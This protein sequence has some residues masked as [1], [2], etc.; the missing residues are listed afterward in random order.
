MAIIV[1]GG[2]RKSTRDLD[3][4][5]ETTKSVEYTESVM[6]DMIQAAMDVGRRA[7]GFSTSGVGLTTVYG[8]DSIQADSTNLSAIVFFYGDCSYGGTH[9]GSMNVKYSAKFDQV[10][11]KATISFSSL[12]VKGREIT[13]TVIV[14]YQG[15]N[16]SGYPLYNVNTT[17]F[18]IHDTTDTWYA[19]YSCNR[20][21]TQLSGNTTPSLADDQYQVTG[22]SSGRS[23]KGNDFDTEIEV[24]I[25]MTGNCFHAVSGK[26]RITP[27]DLRWRRIRFAGTCSSNATLI[28]NGS[29]YEMELID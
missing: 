13:G 3:T 28:L 9:E 14:T 24:P 23:W 11:S 5:E 10:N 7:K 19:T 12:Y 26:I 8:C 21:Y 20:P 27:G 17:D 16:S 15:N 2:C 22:T 4:T 6:F 25:I 18:T 29:E 1:V